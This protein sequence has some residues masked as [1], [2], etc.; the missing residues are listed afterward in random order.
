MAE[1]VVKFPA[2]QKKTEQPGPGEPR[3][4]SSRKSWRL[5]A[6]ERRRMLL[7]VVIPV[8]AVIAGVAFYL[9]G[10]LLLAAVLGSRFVTKPTCDAG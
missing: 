9:S 4:T 2:E 6:R 8:I 7:L 3:N 5:R 10:G 1:P